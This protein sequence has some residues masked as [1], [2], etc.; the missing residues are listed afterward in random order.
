MIDLYQ[1]L[2][3]ETIRLSVFSGHAGTSYKKES[4]GPFYFFISHE[5]DVLPYGC[6]MLGGGGG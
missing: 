5:H 3:V 2:Y 6:T 4:L 1:L